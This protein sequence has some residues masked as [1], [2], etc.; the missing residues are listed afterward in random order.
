MHRSNYKFSTKN[1]QS[2][3]HG[4]FFVF[5]QFPDWKHLIIS[6]RRLCTSSLI[7]VWIVGKTIYAWCAKDWTW[8]CPT[9]ILSSQFWNAS[10]SLQCKIF[11]RKVFRFVFNKWSR[12][13][14]KFENSFG[15][16]LILILNGN[17]S[18]PSS[19]CLEKTLRQLFAQ[20]E[21]M[22]SIFTFLWGDKTSN[23][24]GGTRFFFSTPI[25]NGLEYYTAVRMYVFG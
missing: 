2:Q 13:V 18:T 7:P 4:A 23:T 11:F 19:T 9:K 3:L 20:P 6:S 10:L 14:F 5:Q 21:L 1:E 25:P 15:T 22:R 12:I 24:A 8:F 17:V 16:F